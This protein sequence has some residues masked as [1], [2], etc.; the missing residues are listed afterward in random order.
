VDDILLITNDI[1]LL[2]VVKF[3]WR[4]SFSMKDFA[5]MTCILDIKIYRDIS[6]SLIGLRQCAYIDKILNQFNMQDPKKDFLPMLHV[7]TLSKH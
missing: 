6:K 7:I 5:E 2:E 1:S 4:K 3:S